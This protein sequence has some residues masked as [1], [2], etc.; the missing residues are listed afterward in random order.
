L[1]LEGFG[2]LPHLDRRSALGVRTLAGVYCGLLARMRRTGFDVFEQPPRLSA[3][4][5]AKAVAAL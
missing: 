3:L 2:L 5:K 1:L 4:E